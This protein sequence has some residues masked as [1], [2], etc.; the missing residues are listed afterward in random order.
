MWNQLI[1]C[2]KM[3]QSFKYQRNRVTEYSYM[4]TKKTLS[5]L[6]LGEFLLTFS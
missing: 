3:C 5:C 6:N 1:N 4:L 2:W